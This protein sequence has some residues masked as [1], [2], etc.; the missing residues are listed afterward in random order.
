VIRERASVL[1]YTYI[2]GWIKDLRNEKDRQTCC[3]DWSFWLSVLSLS[4]QKSVWRLETRR[5]DPFPVAP[6]RLLH[7]QSFRFRHCGTVS[8]ILLMHLGFELS[9]CARPLRVP[10][11]GR[12]DCFFED[13]VRTLTYILVFILI[14]DGSTCFKAMSSHWLIKTDPDESICYE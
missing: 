5:L 1:R 14:T 8:A 7:R 10:W 11:K 2:V 12:K 9:L 13:F 3:T 4:S 6:F